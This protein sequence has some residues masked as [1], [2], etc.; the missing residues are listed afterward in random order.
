MAERLRRSKYWNV[1]K[2]VREDVA[3]KGKSSSSISSSLV[4]GRMW[5]I[6]IVC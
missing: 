1:V 4:P 6:R 5:L 3:E 2:V